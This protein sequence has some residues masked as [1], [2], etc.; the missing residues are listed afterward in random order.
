MQFFLRIQDL[1][2][3]LKNK[4]KEISKKEREMEKKEKERLEAD[5]QSEQKYFFSFYFHI[6]ILKSTCRLVFPLKSYTCQTT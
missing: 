1:K 3:E 6:L 4:A 5:K 2:T